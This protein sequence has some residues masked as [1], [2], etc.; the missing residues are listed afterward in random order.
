MQKT[1]LFLYFLIFSLAVHAQLFVARDTINVI[2]NGNTLKMPWAN[3]INF[4]NV[5]NIDL[6]LDGKKD[7]VAFDRINA[8]GV[9]RF[10][11]FINTGIFLA[12]QTTYSANPELSYHFP[13]V[14][15][16][17]VCRDYNCDGKEDLFCSTSAGITV[18]KNTSTPGSLNFALVKSLLYTDYQGTP[19]NLY[20]NTN[21][22]PG[23]ED[24]DGDGDLD[25]L[26]FSPQGSYVEFHKNLS[27]ENGWNCDSLKFQLAS[28]C[29][30]N[31]QESSCAIALNQTCSPRP[32]HV[33][34]TGSEN[35]SMHAGSCLTCLDSDSDGDQDLVMG[36]VSCNIIQFAYNTGSPSYANIT[37]TTRLYP[38]YPNKGNTLQAKLN[39]YPCAYFLDVD[40]DNKKDL[41]A[42]PNTI[43]SENTQSV[44]YYKNTSVTNTVNFQFVKKTLFQD[45][46][47]EVGESSYPVLF[48][49][50]ADGKKDLLI[51]TYGYYV[52]LSGLQARLT[53]YENTG[54]LSQPSYSLIS[55]DYAGLLSYS[56]T[57]VMPTVGDIDG[58][59]AVDILVANQ[60]GQIHW[61]KNLAGPGA[62]CNF[63]FINNPFA[64]AVSPPSLAA[65]AA[66][67]P[68]LFDID[69]DGKLDLM[70][71]G[72]NGKI[73]YYRN[74]GTVTSPSFSFITNSFGNVNVQTLPN[75][76]GPDGYAAPFF[77]D[78]AGST[79]LLVGS[80]SGRINYY[81]VP[82]VT[83][84]CNL[85]SSSAN[86]ITEGS[87]STVF[88]EDIN[89]DNKR[90]LFVGNGSGG[91]S[92]FSSMGP[93][94]GIKE[95]TAEKTS[96]ISL[97][98]NPAKQTLNISVDKI[99][100]ETGQSS[101]TDILGKEICVKQMNSNIETIDIS[102]LQPGIYF[103]KITVSN[104]SQTVSSVKKIIKE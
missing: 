32:A 35:N 80:L 56:L 67:A 48:D 9:G 70:I 101:V 46:M 40:G 58:D 23:I 99:E 12:G 102:A 19:A 22:V 65:P 60:T 52:P 34:K 87:Q 38:N 26:T 82:S 63:T 104:H 66:P 83:A 69:K 16:W 1:F 10:R 71:G 47:I 28:G 55:R 15:N 18:F 103:V 41:V 84:N 57:C 85:I 54:T 75:L 96:L 29:W 90:D 89:N 91:L 73:W 31:I 44:W 33:N 94:V 79:K 8:F 2:E 95:T 93:D 88:F 21:A 76:F 3:G 98:P 6:N 20:A 100:V 39:T 97:F 11:C 51:G 78:E 43:P 37:D 4:S 74:V 59:G 7:I 17:A 86:G 24:I 62:V 36:D 25:I 64:L 72:K 49:Y 61:L 13:Q 68:Q 5:S 42:T 92:F 53:L 45:E 81:S 14:T 27:K 50:N 77:Y 30:G